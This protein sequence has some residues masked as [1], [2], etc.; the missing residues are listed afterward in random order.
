MITVSHIFHVG[1][2][3]FF[4][5]TSISLNFLLFQK[6]FWQEARKPPYVSSMETVI[7][8]T[9]LTKMLDNP[10]QI[11]KFTELSQSLSTNK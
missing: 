7:L 10:E 9:F 2:C 4:S 5:V 3:G 11:L 6:G 8:E 1:I